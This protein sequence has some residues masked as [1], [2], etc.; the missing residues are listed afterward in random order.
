MFEIRK[1]FPE[2]S[3]EDKGSEKGRSCYEVNR[4]DEERRMDKEVRVEEVD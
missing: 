2:F 1:R 4:Q 3:L